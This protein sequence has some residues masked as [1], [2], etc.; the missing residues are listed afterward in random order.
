MSMTTVGNAGSSVAGNI[1]AEMARQRRQ[2]TDL[3]AILNMSQTAI[4]RR[5]NGQVGLDVD[6]LFT[7]AAWL[8]VSIADLFRDVP[9]DDATK[10]RFFREAVAA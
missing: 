9:M 7:I 3:A 8:G 10:S 6:E 5:L 4:S 2:G 1:R